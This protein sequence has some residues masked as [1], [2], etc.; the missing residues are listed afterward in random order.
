METTPKRVG[1]RPG[2]L[3][4]HEW[5]AHSTGVLQLP[6]HPSMKPQPWLVHRE[7]SDTKPQGGLP[8]EL[9]RYQARTS[10]AS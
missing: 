7:G 5:L 3:G 1:A 2:T 6:Y 4:V 8:P 10:Q 9:P